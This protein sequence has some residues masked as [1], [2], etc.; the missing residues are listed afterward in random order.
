[1]YERKNSNIWTPKLA[2]LALS[3]FLGQFVNRKLLLQKYTLQ[4]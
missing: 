3:L 4:Q 2:Q 1:M